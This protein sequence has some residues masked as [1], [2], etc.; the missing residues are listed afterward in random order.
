MFASCVDPNMADPFDP[1]DP[2]LTWGD[3]P[4]WEAVSV[5]QRMSGDGRCQQEILRFSNTKT[6]LITGNGLKGDAEG[7]F[8]WVG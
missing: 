1:I 8:G 6:P 4:G 3:Q 7:F 5:G 2:P